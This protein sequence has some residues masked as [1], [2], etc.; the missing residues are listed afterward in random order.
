MIISLCVWLPV[1]RE[2][3][4]KYFIK[5]VSLAPEVLLINGKPSDRW[6]RDMDVF[7][8]FWPYFFAVI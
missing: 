8:I 2:L 7:D 3:R 4:E 6:T 5:I 1:A